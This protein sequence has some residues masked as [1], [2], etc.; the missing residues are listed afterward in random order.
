MSLIESLSDTPHYSIKSVCAQTGM[1]AVTLRAWERRYNILTPHRTASNYRLYSE[2][3]IAML[4]WLKS[5]VDSGMPIS[6][7]AAELSEM[8]SRGRLPEVL[9]A[10]ETVAQSASP[11]GVPPAMGII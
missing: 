11:T 5:Q 10:L 8:R 6:G 4:R 7:A 2:Q 1:M 9:P 3:D